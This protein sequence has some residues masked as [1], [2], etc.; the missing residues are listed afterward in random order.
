MVYLLRITAVWIFFCAFLQPAP[1]CGAQSSM[2]LKFL[3]QKYYWGTGVQQ[4][5]SKALQLYLQAAENGDTEAQYIAGGMYYKG[6]GTQ[7]NLSRAFSLLHG[8]AVKG[9]STPESQRVLGQ[10]FLV[11]QTIPQNYAEAMK[12]YTLAAENGDK[13]SQSELAVLYFTGRGGVQDL[14]KALFWFEQ[15][16]RQGMAVAQYSLGIMHYTG[17]GTETV[18]LVKAYAWFSQAAGQNHLDAIAARNYI[19]T[20]LSAEQ[21]TEAQDYALQLFQD[22]NN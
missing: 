3:A 14:Q 7:Q 16:A 4:D 10:F 8:A 18:D 17:S 20:I 2:R 6:M 12:W 1:V 22:I 21:V 15:S 19:Q 5:Y 9:S 13:E 11:G